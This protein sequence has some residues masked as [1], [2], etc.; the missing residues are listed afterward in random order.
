MTTHK[1]ILAARIAATN[2]A[3]AEANRLK[4][5]L[6]VALAPFVGQKVA[7]NGGGLVAKAKAAVEAVLPPY[8]HAIHTYKLVSQYSVAYI[9]KSCANYDDGRGHFCAVYHEA[10]VYVGELSGHTLEKLCHI[11]EA[12]P[13][14]KCDYTEAEIIAR[15]EAYKAAKKV[16]DA[17][18]SALG[19][20]GEFDR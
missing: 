4:P 6:L 15:R 7:I 14:L 13:P 2:S 11:T 17:A 18:Q 8:S 12:I 16:A 1:T 20:F 19:H 10:A 9:V 5:L 3:N